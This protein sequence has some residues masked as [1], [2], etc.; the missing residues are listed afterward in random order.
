MRLRNL[1]AKPQ[2]QA[3]LAACKLA[4]CLDQKTPRSPERAADRASDPFLSRQRKGTQ[5]QPAARPPQP[6]PAAAPQPVSVP[7]QNVAA[8]ARAEPADARPAATAGEPAPQVL[9][10]AAGN[11]IAL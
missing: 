2:H 1:L 5:V 10:T 3:R 4:L 6:A 7:A 9:F 8:A 11:G